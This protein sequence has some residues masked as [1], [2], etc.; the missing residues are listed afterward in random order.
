MASGSMPET[1]NILVPRSSL[2]PASQTL[3]D[4]LRLSV[5]APRAIVQLQVATRSMKT[6]GAVRIGDRELAEPQNS[7]K[8]DDPANC[9]IAPDTWLILSSRLESPDLEA[10]VVKACARRACAVTD[11]SDASVTLALDGPRAV[12]VLARGCGLDLSFKAFGTNACIRT[13]FA[14]LPVVLRRLSDQR[15]EF[16]VDR[17]T[18]Q[19]LFDWIRDAATCLD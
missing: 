4:E 12:E 13:R 16:I 14:Q 6:I 9:R 8:G 18:A 5:L 15:F 1:I 10:A 7:C 2:P 17:S 3:A 19:Y 11:L